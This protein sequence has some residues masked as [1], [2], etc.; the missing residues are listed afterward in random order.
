MYRVFVFPVCNEPGLET[1]QALSK[2]N[3]VALFGGSSGEPSHDPAFDMLAGY[4][5]CPWHDAPDFRERFLAILDDNAI[6]LVIPCW[7]P[8]VAEFSSWDMARPRFA[9]SPQETCR[10]LLS[11]R[12]T[13]AAL[14]DVV[15]CPA[16]IED[17]AGW[18]GTAFAKPDRGSGS[19][20]SLL[21]EH[22]CDLEA[23]RKRN[24]LVTEYLPGAEYTVDCFNDLEGNLLLA[25]V[26][27]RSVIGRGIA[28]ASRCVEHAEIEAHCRAIA[29]ALP[30]HG[31][32]FAQFK[33]NAEG[34]PVLLEVNARVGG[35]M[36]LTRHA[37]PNIPLMTVFLFMGETVRAPRIQRDMRITRS[38]TIQPS[39]APFSHVIWD[40]DDTLIRPDG[41]PDPAAMACLYDLRNRGVKQYLMT[42]NP[43][44]RA[45][46]G[47]NLVPD[48][49]DELCV[50]E[51]KLAEL[52]RFCARHAISPADAVMVNDSYVERFAVEAAF[53]ALRVIAPDALAV[54]GR[55]KTGGQ[56]CAPSS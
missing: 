47:R 2:S 50:T 9:T 6:D 42:R 15:P 45:V 55:G 24:L 48:F 13:Y 21:I 38:L 27:E 51:D 54:L 30:L 20:G 22:P 1:L 37:G 4:V 31:A 32:W 19:K 35:S 39:F 12:Q 25:N 5:S 28:L 11:K 29:K 53:P 10:L 3:K 23:A 26:R 40:L 7:D 8:L 17:G 36:G 49:F 18:T 52:P 44:A 43:E 34:R 14:R 41:L 16:I 46:I 56:A 33:E